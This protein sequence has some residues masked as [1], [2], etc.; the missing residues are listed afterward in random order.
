VSVW[1]PRGAAAIDPQDADH[2]VGDAVDRRGDQGAA[3]GLGGDDLA[4]ADDLVDEVG[5][6]L[7]LGGLAG[8]DRRRDR[9]DPAAARLPGLRCREHERTVG[10]ERGQRGVA[11]G[12]RGGV[13]AGG[14][15]GA[16]PVA[17]LGE[18]GELAARAM[19]AGVS[20]RQRHELAAADLHGDVARGPGDRDAVD[21]EVD[22]P[23]R[24]EHDLV[25]G[26]ERAHGDRRAVDQGTRAAAVIDPAQRA[27]AQLDHAVQAGHRGI[28][29]QHQAAVA[30]PDRAAAQR[31][32][33]LAARVG[34]LDHDEA[35][36]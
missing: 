14:R 36:Q 6:S 9:R 16:Q 32:L 18:R 3:A 24:A 34:A 4:R 12:A 11:R 26:L 25:A 8:G 5:R 35:G 1:F 7:E 28:G 22:Q 23:G 29:E 15:L 31:Q 30:A 19:I 10:A 20:Q 2:V 17:E 33:E 27:V 13:A 21:R